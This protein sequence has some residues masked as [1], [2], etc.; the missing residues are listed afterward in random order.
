M[1]SNQTNKLVPAVTKSV[2]AFKTR[3]VMA[4]KGVVSGTFVVAVNESGGGGDNEFNRFRIA[5]QL[6]AADRK[7]QPFTVEKTYN[8]LPNGR[9]I[10]SFVQDFNAWSSSKLTEDDLYQEFDAQKLI[11]GKPVVVNVEHRKVGKEWEAY[12]AAFHPAGYKP[13]VTVGETAATTTEKAA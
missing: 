7:G 9:G 1:K 12:I 5:V 13:D 3:A 6:D 2:F 8:L 10:N 4:P 11:T